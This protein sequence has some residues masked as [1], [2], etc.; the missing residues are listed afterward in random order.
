M[1]SK[2][3]FNPFD[4]IDLYIHLNG[5]QNRTD[6]IFITYSDDKDRHQYL[7][8]EKLRKAIQLFYTKLNYFQ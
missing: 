8:K 4:T 6:P 3:D 1:M 2:F 7:L 5:N